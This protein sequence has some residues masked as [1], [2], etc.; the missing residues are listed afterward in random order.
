MAGLLAGVE[1]GR[2][3]CIG[4]IAGRLTQNGSAGSRIELGVAGD[5]QSLPAP[6]GTDTAQFDVASSL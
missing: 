1:E 6:A 4:D 3:F 2:E 5:R